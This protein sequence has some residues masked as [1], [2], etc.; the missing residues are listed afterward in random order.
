MASTEDDSP[1][2]ETALLPPSLHQKAFGRLLEDETSSIVQT[3]VTKDEQ[4]LAGS[5]V[6][7]RL[8][9]NDYTTI[10]W[11]HDLVRFYCPAQQ[12]KPMN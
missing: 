10:D 11:M 7:E 1:S 8:P 3:H 12:Q 6:G 9:Y 2:E 4:A 5:A